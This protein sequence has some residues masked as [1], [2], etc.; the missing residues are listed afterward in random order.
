MTV[1]TYD[2]IESDPLAKRTIMNQQQQ[3]RT[4][5]GRLKEVHEMWE[6]CFCIF[7]LF[8][9]SFSTCFF[10]QFFV[11]RMNDRKRDGEHK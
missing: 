9:Y 5:R 4:S 8:C 2:M 1:M 6:F 3:C 11:L 10:S 7:I